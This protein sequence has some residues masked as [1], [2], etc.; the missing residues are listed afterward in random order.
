MP[1][2]DRGLSSHG[3]KHILARILGQ[4]GVASDPAE[5]H[6]IDKSRVAPDNLGKRALVAVVGEGSK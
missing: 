2:K 5:R 4:V 1:A 6:R 3:D